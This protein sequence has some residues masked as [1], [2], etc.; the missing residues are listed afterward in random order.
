LDR[1]LV[2][3]EEI[4][5]GIGFRA[6]AVVAKLGATLTGV[7][8]PFELHP[9]LDDKVRRIRCYRSQLDQLFPSWLPG[10]LEE[11][12]PTTERYWAIAVD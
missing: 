10:P 7:L 8:Q 5:H 11:I 4:P 2:V 3:Y 12:M 9:D 1:D 6:D